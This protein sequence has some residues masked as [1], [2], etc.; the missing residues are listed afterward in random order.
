MINIFSYS[1][2][3]EHLEQNT[4]I[5]QILGVLHC[6]SLAYV[7]LFS[8]VS[9]MTVTHRMNPDAFAAI[10]DLSTSYGKKAKGKKGD[11]LCKENTISFNNL[12]FVGKEI[13]DNFNIKSYKQMI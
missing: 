5:E 13:D 6:Y 10:L 12:S 4:L 7:T 8:W 11:H 3:Y 9:S 2:I 1:N